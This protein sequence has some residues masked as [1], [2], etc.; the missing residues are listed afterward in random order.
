MILPITH[1]AYMI[2]LD[3]SYGEG[4]GQIVRNT[5][6]FST[7]TGKAFEINNIRKGRSKP[8]L[9]AQ[10]LHAILDTA[11]FTFRRR[12]KGG[13]DF[14]STAPGKKVS[15]KYI[16]LSLSG[17]WSKRYAV[18]GESYNLNKCKTVYSVITDFIV[19]GS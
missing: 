10:Y 12:N 6:A 14:L 13:K 16:Y 18:K 11:T 8:G 7:L 2:S 17:L 3:G 1:H 9:K 15:K 5:L 19:T 4:G